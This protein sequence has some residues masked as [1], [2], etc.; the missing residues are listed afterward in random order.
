MGGRSFARSFFQ[1]RHVLHVDR[2]RR[3][4]LPCGERGRCR[5][6]MSS[7]LG[8]LRRCLPTLQHARLWGRCSLDVPMRALW[9]RQRRQ[10]CIL[11][12]RSCS[13]AR[14]LWHLVLLRQSPPNQLIS[15]SLREITQ[16]TPND[17]TASFFHSRE[18]NQCWQHG[19]NFFDGY[20]VTH[21]EIFCSVI[22]SVAVAKSFTDVVDAGFDRHSPPLRQQMFRHRKIWNVVRNVP[23]PI[24]KLLARQALWQ[25]AGLV[26]L[27]RCSR[28]GHHQRSKHLRLVR[29]RQLRRPN[30]Q[31]VQRS[32]KCLLRGPLALIHGAPA[33]PSSITT[34]VPGNCAGQVPL[35]EILRAEI[36][37]VLQT[38][39]H[40][41]QRVLNSPLVPI[42]GIV[43]SGWRGRYQILHN[44]ILCS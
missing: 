39:Q 15:F 34:V 43:G 10:S 3:Q 2:L 21:T 1:G 8:G 44:S 38:F 9:G 4:W 28:V 31:A 17:L 27:P 35:V 6:H 33:T 23:Q 37:T 20:Q 13:R 26:A 36:Q 41:S 11:R 32:R 40:S 24:Q 16:S 14:S 18:R 12:I 19:L 42:P 7:L 29:C 5:S 22:Y 30:T 25:R